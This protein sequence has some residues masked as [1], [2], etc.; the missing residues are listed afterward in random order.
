MRLGRYEILRRIAK[1]GMA[2]LFLARQGGASFMDGF[3]KLVVVKR[4]LP[5]LAGDHEFVTMFL[6]EAR[7]AAGLHHSNI[8]L[9]HRAGLR[10]R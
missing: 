3:E 9:K 1:G 5:E 8:V 10:H 7:L 6:D 4:I 2:E